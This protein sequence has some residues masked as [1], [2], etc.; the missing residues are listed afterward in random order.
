M[1]MMMMVA[2]SDPYAY[3]DDTDGSLAV[4][5]EACVATVYSG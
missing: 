3:D 5:M 2:V 4:T 1:M